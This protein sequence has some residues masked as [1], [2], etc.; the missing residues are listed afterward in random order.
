MNTINL[1]LDRNPHWVG[2]LVFAIIGVS[3]A[4]RGNDYHQTQRDVA[5]RVEKL[6][7]LYSCNGIP[8]IYFE[9]RH[10]KDIRLLQRLAFFAAADI[11]MSTATRDGL[12]RFPMEFTLAKQKVNQFSLDGECK[13]GVVIMSEFVSSARV[14]RGSLHINPWR[15]DEVVSALSIALK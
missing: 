10:E 1:F 4:E 15:L 14:M 13:E 9:E 8:L 12:N 11:F 5:H 7:K 2:R 3:A 6:N